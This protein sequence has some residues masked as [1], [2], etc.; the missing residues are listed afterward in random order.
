M[1]SLGSANQKPACSFTHLH[2]GLLIHQI[3]FR[4]EQLSGRP[5]CSCL[6]LG[7]LLLYLTPSPTLRPSI[8]PISPLAGSL[9]FYLLMLVGL[10]GAGLLDFLAPG[11]I[12]PTHL[13]FSRSVRCGS[14]LQPSAEACIMHPPS[15]GWGSFCSQSTFAQAMICTRL[16]VIVLATLFSL[17]KQGLVFLSSS[18]LL[19]HLYLNVSLRASFFIVVIDKLSGWRPRRPNE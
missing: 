3:N 12:S 6:H 14:A 17:N 18:P 2:C 13:H 4:S 1:D 15:T 5:L 7:P 10:A 8:C 11:V 9:L 19:A 16:A